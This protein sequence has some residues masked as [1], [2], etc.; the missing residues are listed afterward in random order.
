MPT[1]EFATI[2]LNSGVKPD[3]PKL[4]SVL[5]TCISEISKADGV[6][7]MHFIKN[8]PQG[9]QEQILGLVGVWASVEAHSAYLASGKML[10]L[11]MDLKDFITMRD[12]MHLKIEELSPSESK[13]ISSDLACAI[14]T[15]KAS[16][17]AKF[18][19]YADN[20]L[21]S[22]VQAVAGWKVKKEESFQ[23]AEEFGR[24]KFGQAAKET[25]PDDVD[26]WVVFLP[27]DKKTVVDKVAENAGQIAQ[28]VEIQFWVRI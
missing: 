8:N 20:L 1:L 24:E 10:P 23:K 15:V 22:D 14:I 7:N 5:Q 18:E 13:L 12:V 11:L 21:S 17:K 27:E 4:L 9:T 2:N 16:D 25:A 6:S 19:E 26:T 3:D 28:G